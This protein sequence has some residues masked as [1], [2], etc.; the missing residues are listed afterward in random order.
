MLLKNDG[1]V[2]PLA[3]EQRIAVIG[4]FAT[5]P[6]FQGAGSSLINPTRVDTAWDELRAVGG[7]NVTYAAGFA[8]EGGAIAASGRSADDLRAEAVAVASAADVAVVFLGLPAAEESEGFDREHIDL[9]AAQLELSL[10]HI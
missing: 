1:D 4:A 5:E 10:I 2:L 3:V 9:P 7:E 6:R 8:V